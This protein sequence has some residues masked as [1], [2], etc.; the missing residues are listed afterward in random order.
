ME[1][2]AA[3]ASV[4]CAVRFALLL[5]HGYRFG[6]VKSATPWTRYYDRRTNRIIYWM[7]MGLH[8]IFLSVCFWAVVYIGFDLL[9]T[10]R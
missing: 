8:A 1:V 3:V 6:Q 10:A 9:R 5:W 7:F 4:A 2:L